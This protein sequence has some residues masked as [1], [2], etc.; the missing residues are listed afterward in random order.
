MTASRRKIPPNPGTAST[1]P[2]VRDLTGSELAAVEIPGHAT[3]TTSAPACLHDDDWLDARL[4]SAAD[5]LCD[6]ARRHSGGPRP[7]PD[8]LRVEPPPA[9]VSDCRPDDLDL[10]SEIPVWRH[11]VGM[12]RVRPAGNAESLVRPACVA[13]DKSQ[14]GG[15][16]DRLE[17]AVVGRAGVHGGF[18]PGSHLGPEARRQAAGK[19]RRHETVR[20]PIHFRVRTAAVSQRCRFPG[21]VAVAIRTGAATIGDP[22][23][24]CRRAHLSEPCR[25][26]AER[27]VRRSACAAA[28]DGR[29][30]C[31]WTAL[32]EGA[33]GG[34]PV[35][36]R[37]LQ[38]REGV[39]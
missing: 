26:P 27:R 20:R 29:V 23:R 25:P 14:A 11:P 8:R 13:S 15:G 12:A 10:R 31:Q 2:T 19:S 6:P 3:R 7:A 39:P 9:V 24:A 21:Q 5:V 33:V 38:A 1:R 16:P 32:R 34:H 28:S 35:L 22:A 4:R 17:R 37:N 18:S 30:G 36:L